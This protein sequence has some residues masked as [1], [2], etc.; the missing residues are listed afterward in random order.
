MTLT[1]LADDGAVRDV[2]HGPDG[3]LEGAHRGTVLVDLS[4]VAPATIRSLAPEAR[5]TGAGILD[6]PVSGSV[7]L[8]ERAS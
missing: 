3:L 7:G 5:A 2:Y 1:M 4:T 6:S 8:A